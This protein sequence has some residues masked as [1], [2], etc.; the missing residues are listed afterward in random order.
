M[1]L[2][3]RHS[4]IS[5]L[6]DRTTVLEAVERMFVELSQGSAQNPVPPSMNGTD[7]ARIIPMVAQS[8]VAEL[9]VAKVLCDAPANR[10]RGLPRQRS[11]MLV[12]STRTGECV[13]LLDGRAITAIRTAAASAV[14]TRY[15]ARPGPAVLGV[16]GAGALAVE[17]V[18]AIRTVRDVTSVLVWSRSE[19]TVE[20]FR[21]ALEG[22][23]LPVRSATSVEEIA[24]CADIVCT[25]TPSVQPILR[26]EWLTTGTHL[27]VVGAAPRPNEREVDGE[28]MARSR[29]V[30]DS[31]ST[32]LSKSGDAVLAL[33]E[34]AVTE[35]DLSTEIGDVITGRRIGRSSDEQITLFDSTG[36]G[37]EDLAVAHLV[38][39]A[40]RER[41]LGM[42]VDLSA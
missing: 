10:A 6:L 36:I 33:A 27:N 21:T 42:E 32:A 26:G 37:A 16:V 11:T 23:D 17:H 13:A 9:A 14:A 25:L 2:V 28:A 30:V 22:D 41:G 19:S 7:D 24:R 8:G 31:R 34:G 4:E 12:T 15:L 18:R 39:T 1:T 29:V 40:A 20:T 35:D 3:L 38:I 5:A